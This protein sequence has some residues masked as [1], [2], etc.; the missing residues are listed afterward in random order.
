MYTGSKDELL[1]EQIL[2][3]FSLPDQMDTVTVGDNFGSTGPAV[4]LRRH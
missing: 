4:V 3:R 2:D 1:S